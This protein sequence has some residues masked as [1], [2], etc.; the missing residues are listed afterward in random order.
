MKTT[1]PIGFSYIRFSSPEQGKGDSLRRQT[2]AAAEWCT[3]NGI[4]LDTSLTLHDKGCSAFKGLHRDN[5]DKH[6]LAL[7]LKLVE[8]G[9]KVRPGDYLIIENLDRLTRENERAALRLWMDLLDKGVN[10]VQLS[11]ETVFKH[12]KTD[13]MDVMRAIIELSRG[14][15]ESARKCERN[16]A[17]WKEKLDRA[18][19][20]KKQPPR[21]KDDRVTESLTDRLPAW[22]QDVDG[23][24]H[25]VPTRAAAVERIYQLAADGCG[26][27]RIIMKLEA[28]KVSPFGGYEEY[29]DEDGNTRRRAPA[30]EHL[31]SGKWTK[32]YVHR[33][34]Q[35]RRAIGEFQPRKA[36]G[37]PDGP[38]LP[39]YFP[40]AVTPELWGAARA[41]V[42]R[43]T[44][45]N[46]HKT[47][48]S[49]K[50]INIF[51]GLVRDARDGG[52]YCC[53]TRS[54]D[55]RHTRIIYSSNSREGRIPML[56]FPYSTFEDGILSQ[57][58]ELDAGEVLGE[59]R[60]PSEV[61]VLSGELTL[62][63]A[64][65]AEAKA[66]LAA[67]GFSPA[68]AD[69]VTGL[70][71]R[72]KDLVEKLSEAQ[73]KA[74]RPLAESWGEAQGLIEMLK[75]AADPDDVR[76]RLRTAL[77]RTV[78]S[79]WVLVV[80]HGRRRLAAVQIWFAGGKSHRDYLLLNHSPWGGAGGNRHPASW[81]ARSL[82]S[83]VKPGA[84][85][86][87]RPDHA[88]RLEKALEDVGPADLEDDD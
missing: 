82:A 85:D 25:L 58:M 12:E 61:A 11:P 8:R 50:H 19:G 22:V 56:T 46:G 55:G 10:I 66:Y 39:G 37:S 28:E 1:P 27:R 53:T 15:S 74:A 42:N 32:S 9:T 4:T 17:A 68:I 38:V 36:D 52:T 47:N 24:L 35:D 64:E 2:Q 67:K 73:Q 78:E 7:F 18:R 60:A 29:E 48:N 20:K 57:L 30:G 81:Q 88:R 14:H 51:A 41:G 16:G 62:V 86:L 76:I 21:R 72:K 75:N 70:E 63:E 45:F 33:I 71:D 26:I 31:G 49:S 79:I 23:V 80:P 84:L 69:H 13:M 83:A 43:R 5:P 3:R 40:R 59:D 44:L 65:L 77:R 87:R 6:A 34:L 54:M